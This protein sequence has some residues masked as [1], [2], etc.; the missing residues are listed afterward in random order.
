MKIGILET[1]IPPGRLGDMH[2]RY[3]A[4]VRDLLGDGHA[5]TTFRAFEGDLPAD[6]AACDAYVITGSEAGVHDGLPWIDGLATFLRAARG[7]AKLVGICFGHQ[8]MAHAFG[9]VVDKAR[10]GWGLGLHRYR[11]T[12]RAPWMDDAA[13]IAVPASHQDQVIAPP[14]GARVI[15]GSGFTPF[16]MLAYGGDAISCQCHPEFT[17]AFAAALV[18]V[19]EAADIPATLKASA[20]ASL[21][22]A[23]DNARLARWINGFLAGDA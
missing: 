22:D 4:M 15:A 9:G 13:E 19:H 11:V 7:R 16:A 6:P 3:D 2:G 1:G 5:F 14:P 8:L 12:G 10:Q 20:R 17:P 18:D 23:N 21:D